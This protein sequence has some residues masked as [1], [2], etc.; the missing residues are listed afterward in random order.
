MTLLEQIQKT[1]QSWM[2]EKNPRTNFLKTVIG[3]LQRLP[4]KNPTDA[5]VI[6]VLTKMINGVKEYPTETSQ[7]ELE[8]Y[9][10]FVPK[11]LTES[12]LNKILVEMVSKYPNKSDMKTIM[13]EM[14]SNY[15]GQYDG[16]EVSRFLQQN[17]N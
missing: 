6:S 5:E 9:E 11:S 16:K 10:M 2:V 7:M 8:V 1:T 12:E 14:K 17:L 3:E 13:G 4:S 15:A